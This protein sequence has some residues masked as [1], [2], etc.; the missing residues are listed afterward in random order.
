[1]SPPETARRRDDFEGCSRDALDPGAYAW[2]AG[3]AGAERTRRENESAFGRRSLRPRV[4]VDVST[5]SPATTVLGQEIELPVLVAPTAFHRLVHPDGGLA[6]AAGAAVAGT[7]MCISTMATASFADIA[8]AA[9]GAP[10]WLQAYHLTDRDRTRALIDAGKGAGASG[11]VITVDAPV[12]GKRDVGSGSGVQMPGP[13]MVI[14][15]ARPWQDCR[16]TIS[17]V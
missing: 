12:R 11:I 3:G 1:M 9:P 13:D 14:N 4:L 5:T 8:A 10:R 17:R 2:F 16:S 7:L 15:V 6:M